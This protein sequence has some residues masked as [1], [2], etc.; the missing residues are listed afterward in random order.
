[1][2]LGKPS[3][4]KLKWMPSIVTMASLV[5][6]PVGLTAE[7]PQRNVNLAL[8]VF[9][10]EREECQRQRVWLLSATPSIAV[11]VER[12]FPPITITQPAQAAKVRGCGKDI[13]TNA[14]TSI[15]FGEDVFV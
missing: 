1:M 13:V 12:L 4:S 8:A 3:K 14:K 15:S 2:P 10:A 9:V 5:A 11:N 6:T 7:T